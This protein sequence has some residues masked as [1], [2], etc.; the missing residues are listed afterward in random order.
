MSI[1]EPR[2]PILAVISWNFTFYDFI[3]VDQEAD[4]QLASVKDIVEGL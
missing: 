2:A 3:T 4:L 1:V